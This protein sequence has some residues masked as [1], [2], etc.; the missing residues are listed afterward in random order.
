MRHG[1][2]VLVLLVAVTSLAAQTDQ[3]RLPSESASLE[4]ASSLFPTIAKNQARPLRIAIQGVEPDVL[5][6]PPE[7]GNWTQGGCNCKR[8]CRNNNTQ[9]KLIDDLAQGCKYTANL[10]CED[11]MACVP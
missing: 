4:L 11:C 5:I 9:C 6:P 1:V 10:V 8:N 2:L 7:D 3:V